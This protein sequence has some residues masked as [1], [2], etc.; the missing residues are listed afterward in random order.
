[1]K[2]ALVP[3]QFAD[4]A[5]LSADYFSV[6]E[7]QIKRIESLLTMVGGRV[8]YGAGPFAALASP[9]PQVLSD[10]SP[11]KHY[12]GYYVGANS[13]EAGGARPHCCHTKEYGLLHKLLAHLGSPRGRA[14]WELSCDCFAF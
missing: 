5:V 10:W 6:P 1:V 4:L 2:G 7:E 8:V 11:L 9:P 13:A 12:D 3:G 14:V